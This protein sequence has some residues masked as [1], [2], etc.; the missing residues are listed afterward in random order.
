[1]RHEAN[2]DLDHSTESN[3]VERNRR[4]E[5]VIVPNY[6]DLEREVEREVELGGVRQQHV[7]VCDN[8]ERGITVDDDRGKNC[9]SSNHDGLIDNDDQEIDALN[10]AAEN[11]IDPLTNDEPSSIIKREIINDVEHEG[12]DEL[13]ACRFEVYDDVLMCYDNENAFKPKVS[14]WEIKRNDAFSGNIP[15]AEYVGEDGKKDRGFLVLVNGVDKEIRIKANY[16]EKFEDWN[17]SANDSMIDGR[18]ISTLMAICIGKRNL[19]AKELHSGTVELIRGKRLLNL[20]CDT[21]I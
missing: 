14:Q 13:V 8:Q 17:S 9:S 3:D 12:V 20:M 2:F 6:N 4:P 16:L 21:S 11:N 15:F 18:Y 7:I 5:L 19:R 10:I 1:M